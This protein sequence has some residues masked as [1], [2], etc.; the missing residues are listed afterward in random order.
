MQRFFDRRTLLL[1]LILIYLGPVRAIM[2]NG[3]SGFSDWIVSTLITIPGIII[4]LSFHE[5]AHA[6]VAY[7]CG[8]VTPKVMGR[9][10]IDP[11]AHVDL[12]GIL[13]LLFIG[14]GW[15]KPVVVN[16]ANFR[17]RRRDSIL[18]GIA[19]VTMNLIVALVF[20]LILKILVSAVPSILTTSFGH[21]IFMVFY[22]V[23]VI[24]ISLMLFNL[25]PVPPLDGF[26]VF[27]EI[28]H[29]EN[30]QFHHFVYRNSMVILLVLIILNVPSMLLSRPIY[31]I[32]SFITTTLF[33]IF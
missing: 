3:A 9:C 27:T 16:P 13:S 7:K 19:G 5:Y 18:V 32:V 15:G 31:A 4:G 20:G 10:T 8:D 1:F 26:N 6:M 14:F 22:Y 25:L 2:T 29:L 12:F 33:H 21:T 30:T 24:N 28:F 17:S 23:I 11:Q